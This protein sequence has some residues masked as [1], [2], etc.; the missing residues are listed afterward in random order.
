MSDNRYLSDSVSES[1]FVDAVSSQ[2]SFGKHD[3]LMVLTSFIRAEY[4]LAANS[5]M[6]KT[7][8]NVI[9]S[10]YVRLSHRVLFLIAEQTRSRTHT[11]VVTTGA[12]E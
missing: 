8:K 10:W 1:R 4:D 9:I 12:H 7:K 6:Y 2:M 11:I 5:K 3:S